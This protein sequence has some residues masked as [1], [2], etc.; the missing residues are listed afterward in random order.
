MAIQPLIIN[1]FDLGAGNSAHKGFGLMRCVNIEAFPGAVKAQKAPASLFIT[2]YSQTFTADA[3]TDVCTDTSGNVPATSTAVQLTTTGTLPAGLSTGT[4]YFIINLS[5]TTFS[6]ATTIANAEALTAIDITDAG[7]GTHTIASISPGTI[8]HIIKDPRTDVRFFH[9]SNGRV[10]YE[11]SGAGVVKLLSGNTLTNSNGN[12]ISL[13]QPSSG[14]KKYLFVYRNAKIDVIDVW[15]TSNLETPVWTND[16]QSLNSA[17]GSGNRHKSI[18]AQDNITYF[19]DDR[20]VGSIKE[21]LGQIFAPGTGATFTFN[22]QALD[23]PLGEVVV[24]IEELGINIYI[25]GSKTDKIY[26][27]NRI[28]DSFFLPLTVPEVNVQRLKNIGGII[29]IL[30]GR[31]GNVYTTQGTYVIHFKKLPEQMTNNAGVLTA[32]PITWGGIGAVNGALIVGAAVQTTGNSGAYLIY[33]DGTLVLDNRPSSGSGNVTA[34]ETTNNF[35]YMGYAS[36]ADVMS[37]NRY[38][39]FE[40]VVQSPLYR[41]ATETEQGSFSVL[42]VVAA[43]KPTSGSG[44]V[45]IGWRADTL[46]SFTT[47]S[48][49]TFS[50]S[51]AFIQKNDGIGLIDLRDIQIQAEVDGIVELLEIR[52]LP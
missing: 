52:L 8:N 16:W 27:W 28:S 18:R 45:R 21:N 26:P 47:L 31:W 39:S 19:T 2:A 51:N 34:F 24:D 1:Q 3:S 43:K 29:Y 41:V 13:F 6:L 12:G 40:G 10:W 37:T 25:S 46:A 30:A 7:T 49:F 44:R 5:T 14:D 48:T 17:N 11:V 9:D 22:N 33:P 4:T 23:M 32:S 35:Y 42:E 38:T 20:Y 15:G 50:S 36:G